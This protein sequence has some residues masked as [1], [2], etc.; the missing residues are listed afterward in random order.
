MD[1]S[2]VLSAS[3]FHQPQLPKH[4]GLLPGAV[5]LGVKRPLAIASALVQVVIVI[6]HGL[7][8]DHQVGGVN[9]WGL[10]G[11]AWKTAFGS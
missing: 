11:W 3:L 2:A 9:I 1:G 7:E 4:A 5:G 10:S 8:A 6:E